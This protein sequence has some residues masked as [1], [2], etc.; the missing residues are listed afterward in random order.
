MSKCKAG[1]TATA[2]MAL[3]LET[4]DDAGRLVKVQLPSATSDLE[5]QHNELA[6][7]LL[8]LK[9]ATSTIEGIARI[10]GK[11]EELP[12]LDDDTLDREA[13]RVK[14]DVLAHNAVRGYGSGVEFKTIFDDYFQN[15]IHFHAAQKAYV[16]VR[17]ALGS[18]GNT[19]E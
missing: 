18:V 7:K 4:F 14:N 3:N 2:I 1:Q 16:R 9:D 19:Q 10:M 15:Q 11:A 17:D 13:E 5:I 8:D 12:V 6:R